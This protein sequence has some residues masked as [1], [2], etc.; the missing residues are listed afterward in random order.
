M[1]LF[2]T[3]KEK[4]YV[5]VY[6]EVEIMMVETKQTYI[7]AVTDVAWSLY[8]LGGLVFKNNNT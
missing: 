3:E 8:G 1:Y 6:T 2:G 4:A 7:K 5:Y